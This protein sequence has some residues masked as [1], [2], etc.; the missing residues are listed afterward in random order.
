MQNNIFS[1]QQ[2][3]TESSWCEP[4][5]VTLSAVVL[6]QLLHVDAA[7]RSLSG[8]TV[9]PCKEQYCPPEPRQLVN[10]LFDAYGAA[11]HKGHIVWWSS[12]F[13]TQNKSKLNLG[14]MAS[15]KIKNSWA[16]IWGSDTAD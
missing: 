7:L 13:W 5:R 2:I 3:Q 15:E 12:D 6:V 8:R 10:H 1:N 16:W 4:A 14:K 9:S 11:C